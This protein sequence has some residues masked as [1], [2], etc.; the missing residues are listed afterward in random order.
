MNMAANMT[1]LAWRLFLIQKSQPDVELINQEMSA[2]TI[3]RV[4]RL[5]HRLNSD[6]PVEK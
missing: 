5:F 4:F 6:L 3:P 2:V 1:E